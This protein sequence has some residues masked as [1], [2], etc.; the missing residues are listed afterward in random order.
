[1][2][3]LGKCGRVSEKWLLSCLCNCWLVILCEHS[4]Y[5]CTHVPSLYHSNIF[6][7]INSQR[8]QCVFRHV[9]LF[10]PLVHFHAVIHDSFTN[11]SFLT[12][13][14]QTYKL[15]SNRT[16]RCTRVVSQARPFTRPLRGG[17]VWY[18]AHTNLVS[19]LQNLEEILCVYF[20][21]SGCG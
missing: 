7:M 5:I 19:F 16:K 17:R 12:G 13:N 9:L 10:S 11:R 14:K 18:I 3:N 4:F 2:G 21:W 1:M 6:S 20:L 8:G 15:H